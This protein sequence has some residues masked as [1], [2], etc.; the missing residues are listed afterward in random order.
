MTGFL[1]YA[2]EFKDWLATPLASRVFPPA[3][4]LPFS[5]IPAEVLAA[6]GDVRGYL[7]SRVCHLL[8]GGA[9]PA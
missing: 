4:I 3:D 2:N 8:F 7:V 5:R 6:H 1:I 9:D